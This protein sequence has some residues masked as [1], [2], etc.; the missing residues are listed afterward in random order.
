MGKWIHRLSEIDI[1]KRIGNCSYCG[2][3][4]LRNRGK[5]K[6]GCSVNRAALD[7]RIRFK[8]DYGII[9]SDKNLPLIPKKCPI[10]QR[11][12][13]LVLD[14]NHENKKIRDWICRDCNSII[15]YVKENV[16]TLKNMVD[17]LNLHK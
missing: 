8:N 11:D 15:G 5:N 2:R 10:C 6:W 14:H 3:V 4:I 16:K 13:K 12:K 17:Y 9:L 1:E 7:R